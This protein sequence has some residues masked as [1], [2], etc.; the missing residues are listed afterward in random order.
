MAKLSIINKRMRFSCSQQWIRQNTYQLGEDAL[1]E[2]SLG[3][4][5]GIVFLV[6]LLQALVVSLPF[7][8]AVL[9]QLGN[10][11]NKDEK[12]KS[13][14]PRLCNYWLKHNPFA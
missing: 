14:R 9:P 6:V 1:V 11:S 5:A 12:L 10:P 7:L 13:V 8:F 4:T 3:L 2:G